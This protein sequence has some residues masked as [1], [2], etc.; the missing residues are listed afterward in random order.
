MMDFDLIVIGGGPGGYTAA[1]HAAKHG[2]SVAIFE[3]SELG[4][5]CLNR[6][7]IPTKALLR[8]SK[9]YHDTK[10]S[11][12]LGVTAQEVAYDMAAMHE[13]MSNS[14]TK[15]RDGIKGLCDKAKVA[16]IKEY[17]KITSP[18]SV[19]AGGKDYSAEKIL[20]AVGGRPSMPK[21]EGIDGQNIHTS[22]EFLQSP[23]D[24]KSLIIIGGGVIGAEFAEIYS[25]LGCKVTMIEAMPRILPQLDREVGQ[26]LSMVLKKKGVDILTDCKVSSLKGSE[27]SVLCSYEKKGEVG[28]VTAEKV[29]I[30]TGRTPSTDKLFAEGFSVATQRGFIEIDD[31]YETSVGGIYAIGDVTVGSSLLAHA[32]EAEGENFAALCYGGETKNTT[33]IPA[34]VFTEPEIATVGLTA[35]EAKE[36]GIAV[37]SV[38]KLTSSNGKSVIEGAERGFVKLIVAE[39]TSAL[40][41]AILM[42]NHA[43]EMIGGI[44]TAIT[45]GVT[46]KELEAT[47]FPHPTIS[48]TIIS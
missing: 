36:R 8:S 47:I 33:L 22:D 11:A 10:N 3:E 37:K 34:A 17:A 30:C 19:E 23:I 46:I 29:L 4:G 13:S 44:T 20:I 40:L 27:Q 28:E 9:L 7:C 26:S 35:E 45:K 32:A 48:E 15:L 31:K 25:R 2:K 21:I 41:G 5:T 18:G 24:P 16:I 1:L 38:K 39:E 42:C 12:A 43:S 14:V 6:G